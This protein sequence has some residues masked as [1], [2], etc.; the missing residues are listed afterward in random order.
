MDDILKYKFVDNVCGK[1]I[2][3]ISFDMV[4]EDTKTFYGVAHYIGL[5]MK[6]I[7]RISAKGSD[8]AFEKALAFYRRGVNM[9][10]AKDGI[11]VIQ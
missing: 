7:G 3:H 4:D 2:S 10:S 6:D 1:S 9:F 8:K 11:V 5:S